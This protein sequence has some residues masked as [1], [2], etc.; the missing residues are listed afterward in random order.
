MTKSIPA[1]RDITQELRVAAAEINSEAAAAQRS[2]DSARKKLKSALRAHREA[3]KSF[4]AKL[5]EKNKIGSR[6]RTL[7]S[8][9][10]IAEGRLVEKQSELQIAQSHQRSYLARAFR[11]VGELERRRIDATGAVLKALA[12]ACS[13][14]MISSPGMVHA[15]N[16]TIESLNSVDKEKDLE[17][18]T[19]VANQCIQNGDS[20]S[21]RQEETIEHLGRELFGSPEIIRQGPLLNLRSLNGLRKKTSEGNGATYW[22]NIVRNQSWE[23]G[24]AILTRAG[25]LHWFASGE[26][27]EPTLPWGPAGGP[28]ISLNLARCSFEPGDAPSWRLVEATSK[29][30][31]LGLGSKAQMASFR[32]T[33]VEACMMWTAD[34][35]EVIA[36][37]GALF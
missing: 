24:Y 37:C 18:F 5:A 12:E 23:E 8:D 15:T 17:E 31:T 27:G 29:G 11:R 28:S 6:S 33:N 3:C 1:I 7:E 13:R 26:D 14:A 19:L 35:R 34:V 21:K 32:A 22:S 2:V 10:W 30:W 20:L 25:F 36:A 16:M 4:D 9:P